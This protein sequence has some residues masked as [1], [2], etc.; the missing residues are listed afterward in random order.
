M[1]HNQI[2]A[3]VFA[4]RDEKYYVKIIPAF[5]HRTCMCRCHF[6]RKDKMRLH[7]NNAHRQTVEMTGKI[8]GPIRLSK[9]N[10]AKGTGM[11]VPIGCDGKRGIL[12]NGRP[13][14][15][16]NFRSNTLGV[17]DFSSAVSGFCQVFIVAP[18]LVA[19]GYGQRYVGLR[20]T[21][22][23]PA[24]R[25]KNLWYPAGRIKVGR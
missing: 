13:F 23:I 5:L 16:E 19:S 21:P 1:C 22:K 4:T 25:E 8:T 14:F 15:P 2:L 12:R 18:P 6:E 7:V 9:Q 10:C 24:A 20:P 17:R 11:S 3:F